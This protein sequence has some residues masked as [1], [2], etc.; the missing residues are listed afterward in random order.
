MVRHIGLRLRAGPTI[1]IIYRYGSL[2]MAQLAD[3]PAW[4]A[5]FT[6]AGIPTTEAKAYARTFN[7]NRIRDPKD[8]NKELL[9]EL[10]IT[11][12][13][14]RIAI[15]K[16]RDG[17]QGSNGE[18]DKPAATKLQPVKVT[19][20]VVQAEMTQAE[21]RKFIIDW[22]VFKQL[23]NI[24]KDQIP[25]HLYNACDAAVQNA[26]INTE[27]KFFQKDEGILLEL[28][29]KIATKRSNPSVHRLAFSNIAQ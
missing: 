22:S 2:H 20:P 19:A 21:F 11:V 13:G 4:E 7:E 3:E 16:H 5:F 6:D 28:L 14:D 26:L 27:T 1:G 10:D 15:L 9:K 18:N 23:S 17:A 25:L 29:Q 24:T 12:L 8:L